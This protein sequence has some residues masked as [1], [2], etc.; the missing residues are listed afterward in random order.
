MKKTITNN[1]NIELVKFSDRA[2]DF[3]KRY[4]LSEIN[5]Q[6]PITLEALDT[7]IDLAQDWEEDFATKEVNPNFI[8]DE[9][10]ATEAMAF[11]SET[12]SVLLFNKAFD[13]D[14]LNLRLQ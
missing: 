8:F 13:L 10:R 2:I 3:I 11:V 14:N 7:I 4:I 12:S 6:L 9:K 1:T 5:M